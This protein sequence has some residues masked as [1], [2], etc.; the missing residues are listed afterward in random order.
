MKTL[1]VVRVVWPNIKIGVSLKRRLKI[2]GIIVKRQNNSTHTVYE[3]TEVD[4]TGTDPN[5]IHVWVDGGGNTG[6]AALGVV[7]VIKGMVSMTFGQYLG[8][9]ST[10]NIA[11]LNAIWKGLRLVKHLK[12]TVRIYSDSDYAIKS[13]CG[14][15]N[16][17][18]NRE[19]IDSIKV[20][21]SEY[22][23]PVDFVKVAGHSGLLFNDYADSIAGWFLTEEKNNGHTKKRKK[24]KK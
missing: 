13:I 2:T 24:V 22:P 19:L 16:G 18:K 5:Y 7:V 12:M 20:Y 11:E 1:P 10:N 6:P 14:E 9:N 17:N 15:Y 23:Y 8:D 21:L 4:L 3:S